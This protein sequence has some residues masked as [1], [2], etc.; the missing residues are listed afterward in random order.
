VTTITV[1]DMTAAD[2]QIAYRRSYYFIAGVGGDTN[3][4]VVGY[5]DLLAKEKI[6]TPISW[7]KAT[8]AQVNDYAFPGGWLSVWSQCFQPGLTI[9]MFPLEGL[10]MGRLAIF[11]IR[12]E[13]RWFDDVIDNMRRN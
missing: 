6:G 11:K 1:Y 8:G 7:L 10:D 4:W 12:M 9:L 3:E 13:D 5:N 2:I